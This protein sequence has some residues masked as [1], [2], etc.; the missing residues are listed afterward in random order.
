MIEDD[1][2]MCVSRN[3]GNVRQW[4][5]IELITFYGNIVIM[6]CYLFKFSILNHERPDDSGSS[7]HDHEDKED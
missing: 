5:N 4:A 2:V 1:T 3:M 7:N 6:I